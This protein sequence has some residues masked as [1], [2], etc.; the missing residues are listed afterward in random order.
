MSEPDEVM[1]RLGEGMALSQRGERSA[2][3]V[4]FATLWEQVGPDGDPLHRCAISH[5]SADV[6]DDPKDELVWDLRA[7]EA[8]GDVTQAR[9]DQAGV[10]SPVA[11]LYP[12][13]HLN[14]GEVYRR[15][16]EHG[17]AAK[18]LREGLDAVSALPDDGYGEMIRRGLNGLA[19]RLA[20]AAAPPPE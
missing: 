11:A 7:L 2:A 15:M 13:L 20:E 4:L 18:H 1:T 10:A 19:E 6:Q 8:A 9:A 14:L 12:S 3:R 5:W 17:R 16:G